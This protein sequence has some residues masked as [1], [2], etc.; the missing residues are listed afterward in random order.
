MRREGKLSRDVSSD[1][2]EEESE[3]DEEQDEDQEEDFDEQV[4]M[5]VEDKNIKFCGIKNLY[6]WHATCFENNKL[7]F[8]I[9]SLPLF[10]LVV[11]IRSI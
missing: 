4:C 11:R 10:I 5:S 2:V 3:E 7:D 6:E 8:T 9:L 1:K